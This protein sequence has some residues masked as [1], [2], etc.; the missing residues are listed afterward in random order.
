M[1]P[2]IIVEQSTVLGRNYRGRTNG[3]RVDSFHM[4]TE[5]PICKTIYRFVPRVMEESRGIDL[6]V[7]CNYV[8]DGL[9]TL[10]IHP[11]YRDSSV[12]GME[13]RV[14]QIGDQIF[15]THRASSAIGPFQIST[16]MVK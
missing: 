13:R 1:K 7:R 3:H 11:F 9:S 4:Y 8:Y 10:R 5:C 14:D 6:C 2:A 15:V 12:G 16:E